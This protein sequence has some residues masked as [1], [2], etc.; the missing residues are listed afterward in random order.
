MWPE[1]F[2]QYRQIMTFEKPIKARFLAE[3]LIAKV[4]IEQ[5][6]QAR[7][8]P[9]RSLSGG[10]TEGHGLQIRLESGQISRQKPLI[11]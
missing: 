3:D 11:F 9:S 4:S 7:F 1:I 2:F 6:P 5:Q 10:G 8:H